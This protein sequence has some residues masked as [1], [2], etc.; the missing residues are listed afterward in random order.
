MGHVR[1]STIDYSR[2]LSASRSIGCAGRSVAQ[3]AC[4][5][6]VSILLVACGSTPTDE[7]R[8][9]E[10]VGE[11]QSTPGGSNAPGTATTTDSANGASEVEE[12]L[13]PEVVQEFDKAVVL[14]TSGDV[15]AA[16]QALND[17]AARYPE[18]SGPSLNLGIL[19]A[20]AGRLE[21]AEKTLKTAIERN[22]DNAPAFNQLGIVYRRLGRFEE[23][24]AAY[25]RAIELDPNYAN[26]Y[27]N[28]G[29]LCDLYLQ[30]P[31]RALDAFERYL[32]LAPAPDDKVNT[33]ISELKAR[34]GSEQRSAGTQ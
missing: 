8:Q 22:P 25:G 34:L 3:V 18:Y 12:P 20:R 32:E 14:M 24:D 1:G 30:Q 33:W 11:M 19:H 31:Q 29:V 4:L 27:L 23:A 9:T 7:A 2:N 17:L 21:Q 15:A 26:A 28:L 6:V 10:R 13:P 16:E 5:A